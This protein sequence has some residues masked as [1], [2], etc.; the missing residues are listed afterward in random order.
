MRDQ[1]HCIDRIAIGPHLCNEVR[2]KANL[3]P[4]GTPLPCTG[5][6]DTVLEAQMPNLLREDLSAIWNRSQVRSIADLTKADLFAANPECQT[7]SLFGVCRAGCR[8]SALLRTGTLLSR[9][10]VVCTIWKN[11]DRAQFENAA[12]AAESI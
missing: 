3:L 9:D 8:A 1:R 2:I 6:A 12:A 11:D 7:C 4:D 5:Y 10:P